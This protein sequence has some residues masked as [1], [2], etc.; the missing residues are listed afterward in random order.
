MTLVN[1]R[2][3]IK[4]D[5]NLRVTWPDGQV[6]HDPAPRVLTARPDP[7]RTRRA[8]KPAGRGP[9]PRSVLATATPVRCES[10][11]VRCGSRVACDFA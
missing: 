8:G 7:I 4:R 5:G 3:L 2:R 1:V 6:T 10:D 9:P 11:C